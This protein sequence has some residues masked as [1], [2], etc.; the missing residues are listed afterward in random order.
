MLILNDDPIIMQVSV[1]LFLVEYT[2]LTHKIDNWI[3]EK[4]KNLILKA[5]NSE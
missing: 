3:K 2:S 5:H 1:N 4:H